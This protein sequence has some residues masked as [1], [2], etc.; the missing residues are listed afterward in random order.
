MNGR[1]KREKYRAKMDLRMNNNLHYVSTCMLLID[2]DSVIFVT[3][4]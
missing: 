1:M 2:I 3:I 4:S